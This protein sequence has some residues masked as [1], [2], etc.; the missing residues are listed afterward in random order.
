MDGAQGL[1]NESDYSNP[2]Q[3]DPCRFMR[4]RENPTEAIHA[5]FVSCTSKHYG[6]GHGLHACP[7]RFFAANELKI[8]LAQLL[9]KYE[10]KIHD[11]CHDLEALP[12]GVNYVAHPEMKLLVRR[13]Q[14]EI[15]LESISC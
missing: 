13:R 10:W 9:L 2:L 5:Q 6:F 1:L 15:D 14:E 3:W 11:E 7:G 4:M 8:I 12:V